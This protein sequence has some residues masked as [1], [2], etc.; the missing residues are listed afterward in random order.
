MTASSTSPA[1]S[2]EAVGAML[3]RRRCSARTDVLA[4]YGGEEFVAILLDYRRGR[5]FPRGPTRRD[6]RYRISS[7][8]HPPA[9][10]AR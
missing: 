3:S 1:T 10:S 5:S 7:C 6:W 2:T 4:R 8:A 9:G